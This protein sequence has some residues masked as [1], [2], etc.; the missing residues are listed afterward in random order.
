METVHISGNC[1]INA[2]SINTCM[3][4][5]LTVNA[6]MVNAFTVNTCM[7]NAQVLVKQ[8]RQ[9]ILHVHWVFSVMCSTAVIKWTTRQWDRYTRCGGI[10]GV[11]D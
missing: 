7:V 6:C 5:A 10:L 1:I 9:K 11:G 4:S 8:R 3:V 2:R